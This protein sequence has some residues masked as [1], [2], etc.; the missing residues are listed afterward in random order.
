[1]NSTNLSLLE[2]LRTQSAESEESWVRFVEVY[3]P[4]LLQ[5]SQRL[6]IPPNDRLD[7]VQDTFAKLLVGIKRY[8]RD[9]HSSFRS[10]LFTVLRNTWLDAKRNSKS[11]MKSPLP[12]LDEPSVSDPAE[13][14]AQGE[15]RNYLLRRIQ[16]LVVADFPKV[17][18]RAFQL[19]VIDGVP[20]HEI[21]AQLGISTN[22]VYLIRSRILRRIREE[23]SGLLD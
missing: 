5:W 23:L 13:E 18:Q 22:A 7:I 12:A 10:W 9:D 20:P 19:S 3:A 21:A 17:S 4:L 1:M 6:A 2:R 15:Y 11:R 16:R 14:W 8:R